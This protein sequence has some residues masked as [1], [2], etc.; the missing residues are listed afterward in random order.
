MRPS[1]TIVATPITGNAQGASLGTTS[2]PPIN[3]GI[4]V[5]MRISLFG[6]GLKTRRTLLLVGQ[7]IAS[8]AAA[9]TAMGV[10]SILPPIKKGWSSGHE[11]DCI[12]HRASE[13]EGSQSSRRHAREEADHEGPSGE[14]LQGCSPQARSLRGLLTMGYCNSNGLVDGNIPAGKPCPFLDECG[15][16][17]D[18][19][20]T[21]DK[22]KEVDFSCAAARL[23]SLTKK[24]K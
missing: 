17:F 11:Q 7:P 21:P 1:W 24:S 14:A 2:I 8:H 5:R 3:T 22:P 18:R 15:L 23:F 20:P 16:R 4:L 9:P 13:T 12:H 6:Q 10:P 19:C